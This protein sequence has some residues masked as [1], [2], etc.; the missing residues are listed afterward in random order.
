VR[1][2]RRIVNLLR[3]I[4]L[5]LLLLGSWRAVA[6]DGVDP[7]GQAGK[8]I[9]IRLKNDFIK[10]Y[11]LRAT[12]ETEMT[13]D[14][15]GKVHTAKADADM[16]NSGRA[17]EVGLP[18]VAELMNAKE[19]PAQ[20][21]AL[22]QAAG[23][24]IKVN[25]AWRLWCE[26]AGGK[27]QV[28]GAKLDPFTTANPDHVFEIH[29][30]TQVGE[31]DTRA[32]IHVIQGYTPKEAHA[33]FVHYE[34]VKCKI[35]AADKTTTIRT[36]MAGYNYV[37]FV[38]QS[39]EEPADH[40]VVS[41]GRFVMCQVRDLDGEL[42]VRQVRM[43]FIKGTEAEEMV[44]ELAKEGRRAILGMPRIDLSLVSYRVAHKDDESK[45]LTW[46]LPY[47]MIVVGA[48]PEGETPSP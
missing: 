26:H 19:M 4:A 2:T 5:A 13:I 39:L 44:K 32:T 42:I 10:K 9:V 41:D 43:V 16:H 40:K 29:P 24:Q 11:K 31:K 46:N 1:S 25:G 18:I 8:D 6:Q 14:V 22:E 48:Y 45:P 33:A 21:K 47:E 3:G 15:P 20:V 36:S 34:N 35:E 12:I 27:A 23:K 17:D 28:Q 37:K 38:I 30:I 7:E